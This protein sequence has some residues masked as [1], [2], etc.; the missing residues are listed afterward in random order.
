MGIHQQKYCR[1]KYIIAAAIIGILTL[2]CVI[3][4]LLPKQVYEWDGAYVF[5]RGAASENSVVYEGISLKPGVYRVQLEYQADMDLR[6][7]CTVRDGTV[8]SGG[9]LTNGQGLC[10]GLDKT[11]FQMWLF[12]STDNL[13]VC[14]NYGG[15]EYLRTGRLVIRETGQLWSMLLTIVLGLVF[16][17]LGLLH[18]RTLD[19]TRKTIF[20]WGAVIALIAS[21]PYLS[22]NNCAG[23]DLIFHLER[24]E[25]VKDGLLSG[26]FPVRL[27]PEW[28][29]GHGYADGVMYCNALLIFP[30]LLRLL[31]FTVLTSYNVYCIALN[32]ATVWIAYYCF[33]GIFRDRC[34]GLVCSAL[35]SLSVFRIYKLVITSAT[36]EGSAVTFMP[37]VLYGYFRVFAENP[38]EKG[39]KTAWIPLA[40]GYAGLI[41]THVLTCEIAAFLTLAM[42]LA[43]IKRIFRKEVFLELCKAAWAAL[44]ISLWFLVPFLDYYLREDL[45]IR[46]WA[47]RKIQSVGLYP[48]QLAFHY[49]K[50]GSNSIGNN[51]GMRHSYPMGVGLVLVIGFAVFGVLWFS[52]KWRGKDSRIASVGKASFVFG[53]MLMLMSLEAFPWDK[54]QSLNSVTE[55]LVG[56]MEFPHRFL[57]WATVFLVCSFGCCLWFCRERADKWG[58]YAG[59]VVALIGITTSSMY[60]LDFVDEEMGQYWIYNKEGMGYAYIAD[61]EYLVQETDA[62]LLTFRGALT[63]AKTQVSA[64]EK[65]YLHVDMDCYNAGDSEG[66]VDLPMLYYTGYR[67][68]V[69]QTG[70]RLKVQKGDNN[71]VRVVIPAHFSGTVEVKF[72]SPIHWRVSEALSYIGWSLIAVFGFTVWRKGKAKEG[73]K[74]KS[75]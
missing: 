34:I 7:H 72:V 9:L 35:Y 12:E 19:R 70:E 6:S 65:K 46:H 1:A 36:G 32:I 10:Q 60:L 54:I 58:Y 41:Q 61:G 51:L 14:I 3:R 44:M 18:L 8:F 2:Y 62:G 23:I 56:S 71:V 69:E 37:L 64:Y 49:W 31:G 57:G 5:E 63:D 22:G 39:Y 33:S 75:L 74:C 11:D 29:F 38:K 28:I 17:W 30:A 40:F 55:A 26:Q 25:G 73:K 15:E 53:G 47:A 50:V 48:A 52:G 13:Q 59:I 20:F 45:H 43:F 21:F 66:Y 16:A 67:A 68:Y 24:I 4:L 27:S 42:C